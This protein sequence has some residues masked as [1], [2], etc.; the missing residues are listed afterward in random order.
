MVES[1]FHFTAEKEKS[2]FRKWLAQYRNYVIT[3]IQR[4]LHHRY[5][6]MVQQQSFASQ[7]EMIWRSRN[8]VDFFYQ[9]T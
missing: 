5:R 3:N 4:H 8:T 6:K 9:R 7:L 2:M 1:Y